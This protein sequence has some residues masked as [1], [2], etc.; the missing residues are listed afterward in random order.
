MK[1]PRKPL[2]FN[3]LFSKVLGGPDGTERLTKI[4]SSGIGPAQD[5]TYRHWETLRYLTPPNDLT[6]EEWWLGIKMARSFM[7]HHLPLLGKDGTPM[8]FTTPDI[9]YKMCSVIDQNATGSIQAN[10]PILSSTDRD[11]YLFKSLTDESITSSQLEGASTTGDVAKEMIRTG[12]Q[13]MNKSER[14][15]YNN[16]LAMR[17]IRTIKDQPLTPEIIFEI[18]RRITHGTLDEADAAGRL[19]RDG[20]DIRVFDETTGEIL[21]SPPHASELKARMKTMCA[22][23]NDIDS[24]NYIHPVIRAILIHFWLAYDHP[25]VDGNGRTARA[26]FYWS[27]ARQKYWL[28]EFISISKIINEGAIRYAMAYL[29]TETDDFDT[30]YFILNQLGVVIRAID[31]LHA[32]LRRKETEIMEVREYLA[33]SNLAAVMFNYRQ[34]AVIN[35]ALKHSHSVYTSESH[36]RSHNVSPQTARTDL[37]ELAKHNLLIQERRGHSFIFYAPSD[38]K[39]RLKALTISNDDKS[40]QSPSLKTKA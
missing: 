28:F 23:A 25:F 24:E 39:S 21:H 16:Y 32:Y 33:K 18:H 11:F 35:H 27:M 6:H 10:E 37:L 22:F 38:I 31:E 9:L 13:P 3:V 12:R 40:G 20:E 14:M 34:M 2:S 1:I 36:R 5:G 8:H 30:T 15:I 26:L 7:Q 29:Y 17:F 4:I 19:R